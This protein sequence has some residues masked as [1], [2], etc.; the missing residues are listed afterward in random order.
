MRIRSF[1]R[2]VLLLTLL[3]PSLPAF[4]SPS[5][6]QQLNQLFVGRSFTIRNFY[7]GG[8]LRYGSDGLLLGKAEPGYWSRDGMV[9]FFSVKLSQD[10]TLVMQ[11]NRYCIQFEPE[12]GEFVNV[13]TD[14]KV[15]IEIQLKPDQL[16][17]EALIPVLQKI[18]L[19]SRDRLAD[20]VPSYWRNCL[21]RMVVRQALTLGMRSR[22]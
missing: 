12:Y 13:R 3:M 19:S 11:G 5:L 17:R 4:A 1:N 14:D 21:S 16:S 9:Q 15:E 10:G 2:V 6:E 8:H 20:L 7:H 18:L 22:W